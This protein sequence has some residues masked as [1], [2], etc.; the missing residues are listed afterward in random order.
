MTEDKAQ[1]RAA[2]IANDS[3]LGE[4]KVGIIPGI[5][6]EYESEIYGHRIYKTSVMDTFGHFLSYWQP[7]MA[8]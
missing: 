2:H 1:N 6:P 5:R 7:V 3:N 8:I 4:N